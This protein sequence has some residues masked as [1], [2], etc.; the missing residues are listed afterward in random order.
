M[1]GTAQTADFQSRSH[2]GEEQGGGGNRNKEGRE[3]PAPSHLCEV[4]DEIIFTG[5][6]PLIH[7]TFQMWHFKDTYGLR[8]DQERRKSA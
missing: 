8:V 6:P 7:Y 5:A 4:Q 1:S 3:T 2:T